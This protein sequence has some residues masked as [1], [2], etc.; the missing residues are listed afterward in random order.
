MNY[1]I[2]IGLFLFVVILSE[3]CSDPAYTAECATVDSLQAQLKQAA[4]DLKK[5]DHKMAEEMAEEVEKNA[6]YIQ[7]NVNR[8][9]DTIDLKTALLLSDYRALAMPLEG[10]AKNH[11]LLVAAIDSTSMNL[12]NLMADL[13]NNALAEGLTPAG[14]V[15]R[16][17]EQVNQLCGYV[18]SMQGQIQS[19]RASMDTLYPRVKAFMQ[20]L[21]TKTGNQSEEDS[22]QKDN[23]KT[24]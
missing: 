9:G 18:A 1:R 4:A 23:F 11:R 17:R 21:S 6:Q 8:A 22:E 7:V 2:L 16:E 13:K 3:S 10:V 24:N 19:V 12:T 14:T 5:I 15:A 20:E